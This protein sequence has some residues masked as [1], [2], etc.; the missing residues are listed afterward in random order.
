MV[1]DCRLL[2]CACVCVK[3]Y[4]H[5]WFWQM[6]DPTV[7]FWKW[8]HLLFSCPGLL[9]VLKIWPH[10]SKCTQAEIKHAFNY[11][12][13]HIHLHPARMLLLYV[14]IWLK[15]KKSS[16]GQPIRITSNAETHLY[17]HLVSVTFMHIIFSK[18]FASAKNKRSGHRSSMNMMH[19]QLVHICPVVLQLGSPSYK[20]K[21]PYY[22]RALTGMYM[23]IYSELGSSWC[24]CLTLN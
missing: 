10:L 15:K 24:L 2:L 21:K 11:R 3:V 14:F 17:K 22:H 8:V 23:Q 5:A 9:N 7:L 13:S 1:C 4:V 12:S 20:N 16:G 19:I 18:H 6:R